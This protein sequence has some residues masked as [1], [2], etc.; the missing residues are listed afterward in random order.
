MD[1]LIVNK[2]ERLSSC[3]SLVMIQCVGCRNEDRNYCSRVC[4][5]HAVKNAL[6]LKEKNP[7]MHIYIL[8][9]DMRTYGFREDAYREA[10]EKDVRFI[11]YTPADKPEVATAKEGGK[12]VIR[13]TVTDQILGQRIQETLGRMAA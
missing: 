8:F 1:S 10:C 5:S 7:D 4:C 3:E 11:G 2:D 13:V 6:Q 9:R 12:D